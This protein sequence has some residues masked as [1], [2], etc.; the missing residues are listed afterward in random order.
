[1]DSFI[2]SWSKLKKIAEETIRIPV[3]YTI[4]IFLNILIYL[5][6]G[7]TVSAIVTSNSLLT[8]FLSICLDSLFLVYNHFLL[9][10]IVTIFAVFLIF[11]LFEKTSVFEHLPKDIKYVDGTVESW[12]PVN[13]IRGLLTLIFSLS[14]HYFICFSI[15]L[16][17]LKPT[18]FSIKA[19]Y[20]ILGNEQRTLIN[21]LWYLNYAVLFRSIIRA[22]FVIRYKDE[23]RRLKFS[24]TRYNLITEF[25]VSNRN[26]TAQYMIVKDTYDFKNY[27][28][29]KSLTH[30]RVFKSS[31][32]LG[33]TGSE[34]FVIEEI[35][36][37]K[38]KYQILDKTENL[39]D[40]LYYY[41]ELKEKFK[42]ENT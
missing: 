9:I 41:D 31:K 10:F 3:I 38:R 6:K 34:G 11:I 26:Q 30:K 27:Y 2:E 35:P 29:L 4:F 15:L 33:L 12:N 25:T 20:I 39:S 24:N 37:L 17:V 19:H 16:F 18:Y 32:S 14:T 28:L 23:E 22:L 13:A 7:S 1:M 8:K 42:K 36:P 21:T 5:D 40:I